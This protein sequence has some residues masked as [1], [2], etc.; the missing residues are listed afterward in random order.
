MSGKSKSE[1]WKL[2][3][4]LL[5]VSISSMTECLNSWNISW[6]KRFMMSHFCFFLLLLLLFK[7]FTIKFSG[8]RHSKVTF[9]PF[10]KS[11]AINNSNGACAG[12][13]CEVQR[14]DYIHLL[15]GIGAKVI[16]SCIY[17]C[18]NFIQN[19]ARR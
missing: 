11:R 17:I 10:V 7:I 8:F 13:Q 12:P 18:Y 9:T 16:F 14:R 5:L 1:T 19:Q 4:R 2:W 15:I 6:Q 3:R